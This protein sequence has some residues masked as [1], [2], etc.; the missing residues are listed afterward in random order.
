MP[1]AGKDAFGRYD[2]ISAYRWRIGLH[3][4]E[5][6]S[7]HLKP[8]TSFQ[9]KHLVLATRQDTHLPTNYHR[10]TRKRVDRQCR[11]TMSG[12]I[13]APGEGTS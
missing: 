3:R 1:E 13:R 7:A 5:K 8:N 4:V 12:G 6:P 2:D 11:L 9:T 10:K